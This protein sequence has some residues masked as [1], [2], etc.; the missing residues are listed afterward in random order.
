MVQR[1]R[2]M[3]PSQRPRE[4]LLEW[5]PE[6]LKEAE[7][8]AV[9]LRTGREGEGALAT[10]EAMLARSGGL[11][12]LARLGREDLMRLPGIGPAKA[13]TL[14][15]ALELGNRLARAEMRQA[16]RLD[17]PTVSGAFLVR[18][19][20]AKKNELFGFLSLDGRHRLLRIRELSRGTRTQ[21]PVDT[22]ELFRVALLDDAVG[23]LLFHNHPSG[24][25]V[26]SRDD[27][28]LT[29]RLAEAGRALGVAVHDHIIVAGARWV[30][31][32][33]LRPELFTSHGG[34]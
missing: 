13:A 9:L 21:A 18:Q 31:L 15:A 12:E 10:A 14:L 16:E 5:G 23:V 19:Y 33:Q 6:S 34:D 25:L 7:L 32:R 28:D 8:I 29:R 4:R 30:S 11:A 17:D 1:I 22:A 27:V 3:E 20:R 2:E 26:P 24:E